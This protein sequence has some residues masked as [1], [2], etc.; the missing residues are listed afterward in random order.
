M[1]SSSDVVCKPLRTAQLFHEAIAVN[2][3]VTAVWSSRPVLCVD[4]LAPRKSNF[5]PTTTSAATYPALP[6]QSILTRAPAQG[7]SRLPDPICCPTRLHHSRVCQ[8]LGHSG[9]K[10]ATARD[11]GKDASRNGVGSRGSPCFSVRTSDAPAVT[12]ST[13]GDSHRRETGKP[14]QRGGLSAGLAAVT[15]TV[16]RCLPASRLFWVWCEDTTKTDLVPGDALTR[17][18]D[19]MFQGKRPGHPGW[20]LPLAELGRERLWPPGELCQVAPRQAQP[21]LSSVTPGENLGT[22]RLGF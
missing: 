22:P 9:P 19:R 18:V 10:R 7:T 21:R 16:P 14:K 11:G 2:E 12:R 20:F 1:E 17:C 5:H 3:K 8:L 6:S 4:E 15:A 13:S